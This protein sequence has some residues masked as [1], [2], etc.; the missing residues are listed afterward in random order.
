MADLAHERRMLVDNTAK[1]AGGE[2][3]FRVLP[4]QYVRYRNGSGW[5]AGLEPVSIPV[6]GFSNVPN[7]ERQV[8]GIDFVSEGRMLS[9]FN[10]AGHVGFPT[11]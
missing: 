7:T 5:T 8:T 2:P 1:K 10:I 9:L 3:V 11:G 6:G 4:W